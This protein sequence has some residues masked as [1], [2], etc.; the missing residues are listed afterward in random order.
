[1]TT[2]FESPSPDVIAAR[3]VHNFVEDSFNCAEGIVAAL[4]EAE[5][6]PPRALTTLATPFG[7]GIGSL[8]HV[9]GALTGGLMML[10]KRAGD[11]E[12]PRSEVRRRA[13]ELYR[14]FEEQFGTVD[15]RTLTAHDCNA[16]GGAA[17]DLRSCAKYLR[18]VTDTVLELEK[19]S[20]AGSRAG[21]AV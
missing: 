1:M 8:G 9:C 4:S 19:P 3:A 11:A 6:L 13:Q 20:V 17:Y 18:L 12:V 15:C 7:G 16:A 2:P 5:G 10:G 14:R 21:N